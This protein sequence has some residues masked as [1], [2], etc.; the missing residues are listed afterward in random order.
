MDQQ[1]NQ[2][3]NRED[4][5]SIIPLGGIE[6]VTRN[7]YVYEYKD[8]ILI[9]DC[10]IGFADETMLGV[11]LVLPD[12]TYLLQTPKKIV[13]MVLSH[14]H[15][16]HIGAVPLLMPQIVEKKGEFPIYASRLTAAL[17]NEKLKEF[18]L[19]PKVQ[20]V[21]LEGNNLVKIGS[22]TVKFIR[23]THSVPDTS[24]IFISTPVG[25]FYHGSDYKFDLTPADG[26]SSNFQEIAKT[27]DQNVIALLSD[28]LGA[29]HPGFSESEEH[30]A[31]KISQVM[32]NCKGKFILTTYSS[33]ISRLNQTIASAE[34]FNRKICF[35]GR[36]LIKVKDLGIKLDLLRMKVG[37]EITLNELKNYSDK[38]VVLI[39]AGSQ[40][41]QNS[42]LTR[43]AEGEHKDIKILP[44]DV[45][46]FSS[47]PIP[48]NE[49]SVYSLID[50]LGKRGAKVIYSDLS[51]EFHVS[52]HGYA[53]DIML[54]MALTKP[55]FVIP[56]GGTYRHMLA[57]R[58]LAEKMGYK[59]KQIQLL[60]NGQELIFSKNNVTRGRKVPI[61]NVYVDQ[62]S[63]EEVEGFILRD[64]EKLAH[65]GIV[66]IMTEVMKEDGQ[67]GDNFGLVTRGFTGVDSKK[68]ESG[69]LKEIRA[70]LSNKKERVSNWVH[71]RRMIENIASKY[72]D[73]KLHRKPLVMSVVI[74]V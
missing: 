52:G 21:D 72:V 30:L 50:T 31:G 20:S 57:Y 59:R 9:V 69:L 38:Q 35:V 73:K 23:V 44:D 70:K 54:L 56:I 40:G 17:T 11:D 41:Q 3:Q 8:E 42:A 10:G 25:N 37:T 55:Q 19:E 53:K 51:G 68:L 62:T 71:M 64:R 6:D 4:S 29:E 49:I 46:V 36:S 13:G 27:A 22:F 74:E 60:E 32:E 2:P 47:D 67:V 63:G 43:I 24:H 5:V 14:G 15:E 48:G 16:D 34:K 33:H 61:R 1:N 18:G 58:I 39:V 28:C 66:V 12:I 7:L 26:K 65:D 45:V